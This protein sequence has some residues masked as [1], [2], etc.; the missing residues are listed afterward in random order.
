MRGR[1]TGVTTGG[2]YFQAEVEASLL[3]NCRGSNYGMICQVLST[4]ITHAESAQ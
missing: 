4:Y 1:Y 3:R 2:R